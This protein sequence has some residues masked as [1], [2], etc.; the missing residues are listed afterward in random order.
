MVYEIS[1]GRVRVRIGGA[2]LTLSVS[3]SFALLLLSSLFLSPLFV[4]PLL[5]SLLPHSELVFSALFLFLLSIG[6]SYSSVLTLLALLTCEVGKGFFISVAVMGRSLGGF[7]LLEAPPSSV[8]PY[9]SV[10]VDGA[11]LP[12]DVCIN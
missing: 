2:F 3:L 5:L 12:L 10:V 4:S 1:Y 8:G 7:C 9:F 11:F 6:F